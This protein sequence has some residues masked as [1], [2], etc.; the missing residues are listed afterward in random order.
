MAP[1][2]RPL[3]P[4]ERREALVAAT[5]PLLHSHGRDVS[6]R[7][8][9]EA[10][11]VAEGTIFRAFESKDELVGAATLRAFNTSTF[12]DR[13]AEV[14]LALPLPTRLLQMTDLLHARFSDT[15][16]LLGKLGLT[17]PPEGLAASPEHAR[18]VERTVH[19]MVALLEPDRDRFRVPLLEVVRLLRLLTFSGA[20]PQLNHGDPLSPE[21]IVDVLLHGVLAPTE[22]GAR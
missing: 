8:I 18:A 12:A 4:S 20:H 11:G 15:F 22:G 14:D 2:A 5:V 7:Q 9:A 19:A 21:Q 3:P 17:A 10:A 1:R 16:E 6:T 13:L